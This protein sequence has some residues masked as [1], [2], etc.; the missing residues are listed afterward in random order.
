MKGSEAARKP[1][2]AISYKPGL[3]NMMPCERER[4]LNSRAESKL[5]CTKQGRVDEGLLQ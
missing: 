4:M 5:K 1:I 3:T 2:K